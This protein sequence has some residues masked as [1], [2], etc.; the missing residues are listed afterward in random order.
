LFRKGSLTA[1][2][3]LAIGLATHDHCLA[4]NPQQQL[5]DIAR[6]TYKQGNRAGRITIVWWLVP[7]F[8]RAAL[9]ASGT[10]PADKI[11]ELVS[12]IRDV[13]VFVVIDAKVSGFGGAD[14]VP[15]DEL[16]KKLAVWDGQ[17]KPVPMIP[18][19]KQS[20]ATKNLLAMMKP[21]MANMLGEFGKN[22]AFFVFEGKGQHGSRRIDPSMPGSLVVKLNAEEF[23]WRLPLGSLLPQKIC[24]KC[25]ETFPGNYAFCPFDATPLKE[26]AGEKN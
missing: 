12:S 11:H 14:Y 13:N 20:S 4:E 8:W 9:A 15:A 22:T 10:V 1:F 3:L 26:K 7:E 25:N 18:S 19:E 2:F 23:R 17:G 24:P 16:Q 5:N 21:V 6:D